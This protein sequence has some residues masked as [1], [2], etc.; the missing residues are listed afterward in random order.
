MQ[1]AIKPRLS[2][3]EVAALVHRGLDEPGRI[4][5]IREYTDGWFN[6]AHG[7]SLGDGRELVLKVAPAPDLALRRFTMRTRTPGSC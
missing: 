7:V 6:A 1:S 3:A 5:A 2:P 4:I